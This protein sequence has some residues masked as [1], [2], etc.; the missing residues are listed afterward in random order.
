MIYNLSTSK[1]MKKQLESDFKTMMSSIGTSQPDPAW[2]INGEF[3]VTKKDH[4]ED[5]IKLGDGGYGSVFLGEFLNIGLA[6]KK[7]HQDEDFDEREV[8]LCFELRHPNIIRL[9][10]ASAAVSN[11]PPALYFELVDGPSLRRVFSSASKMSVPGELKMKISREIASGMT[12]LHSQ[13]PIIIHRD[14]KPDNILLTSGLQVKII[15]FGLS[16]FVKASASARQQSKV[17]GTEVY[18]SPE[19]LLNRKIDHKVDV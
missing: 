16:V 10:G 15:D 3:V 12:Y 17:V 18:S 19:V 9:L 11:L 8:E 14:L 6:K 7:F 2:N 1:D 5:V 13:N 4:R